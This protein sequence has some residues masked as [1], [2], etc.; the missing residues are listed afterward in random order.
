MHRENFRYYIRL[1]AMCIILQIIFLKANCQDTIR[2]I[3]IKNSIY[4]DCATLIYV[5]M[6][7]FNYERTIFQTTQLKVNA[8][9]GVGGWYWTTISQKYKGY[10]S[11]PFSFNFLI[12]S[13]NNYFETDL[14]T[15]YTVVREGTAK[16][17]P[18]FFPIINLG[19]RYQRQ[20]GKGLIFRSFIGFTGIGIGI[21]KA[22]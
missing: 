11:L 18:P 4:V 14:G 16:N 21:G 7:S 13:G 3:Y 15:R 9:V 5:G 19:Y 17:K 8:N 1:L 22:F 12:G 20:D 10:Y 6:Y 2:I